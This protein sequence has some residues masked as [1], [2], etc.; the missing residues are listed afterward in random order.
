MWLHS[1]KQTASTGEALSSAR[2]SLDRGE[3]IFGSSFVIFLSFFLIQTN[4]KMPFFIC[5][6]TFFKLSSTLPYPNVSTTT[7]IPMA[8]EMIARLLN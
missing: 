5:S 3:W 7:T 1:E 2:R 4:A 8:K 6:L